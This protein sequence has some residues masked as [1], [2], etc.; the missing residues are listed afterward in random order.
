MPDK[1]PQKHEH[2]KTGKTIKQRRAEKRAKH[3]MEMP[4]DPVAQARKRSR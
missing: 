1:T 2:K 4:T 3:D